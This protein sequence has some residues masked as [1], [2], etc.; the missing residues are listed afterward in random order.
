MSERLS[1]LKLK[2]EQ[3]EAIYAVYGG[4]DVFVCLPTGFGISVCFQILPFL[5]DY[6]RVLVGGLL[7][8]CTVL[9]CQVPAYRETE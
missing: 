6:K 3:K 1:D 4:K 9:R 5:F 2:N 8:R 7:D